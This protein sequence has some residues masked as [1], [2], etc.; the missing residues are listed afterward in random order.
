MRLEENTSQWDRFVEL[1]FPLKFK[2]NLFEVTNPN[3]VLEGEK[4]TV[5]EIGPY[6]Y[7]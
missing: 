7:E 5:R 6:T 4:P 3:E 2:A 1:P